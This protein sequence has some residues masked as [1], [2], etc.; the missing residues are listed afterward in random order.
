MVLDGRLEVPVADPAARLDGPGHLGHGLIHRPRRCQRQGQA[1]R[2]R[3]RCRRVG[4]AGGQLDAPGERVARGRG[5]ATA[6]RHQPEKPLRDADEVRVVE[7]DGDVADRRG[8]VAGDLELAGP[9][10]DDATFDE[11][12]R[13]L[14]LGQLV[15]PPGR[16]RGG[17]RPRRGPL[18]GDGRGRGRSRSPAGQPVTRGR[19]PSRARRSPPGTRRGEPGARRSGRAPRRPPGRRARWPPRGGR[20]PRDWHRPS[21]PGRRP[22]GTRRPPRSSGPPRARDRRSARTASGHPAR[23]NAGSPRSAAAVRRWRS[24]RRARLVAS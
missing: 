1:G 16:T 13:A 10:R 18:A 9:E 14:W 24:R 17:S 8:G 4:V 15:R 3:D 7:P 2:G 23:R 6:K 21:R 22:R 20:S 12:P 19:R 11:G 5:V